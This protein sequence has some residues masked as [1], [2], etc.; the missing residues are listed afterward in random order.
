MR[1]AALQGCQKPGEKYLVAQALV[2]QY[3]YP[4]FAEILREGCAI[5]ALGDRSGA[6][7]FQKML[8]PVPVVAV[9]EQIVGERG[10][11]IDMLRI[12][13]KRPRIIFRCALAVT[14]VAQGIA[15]IAQQVG[16]VRR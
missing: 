2:S 15:D 8:P 16:V 10:M 6:C 11:C 3:N 4:L 12:D 9:R 13:L 1:A 5:E 14:G 7:S